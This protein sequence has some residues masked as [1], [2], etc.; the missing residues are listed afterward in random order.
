MQTGLVAPV[1]Q[2]DL[3]RVELAAM[4]RRKSAGL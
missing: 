3:Q 2:I 4:Q 1:A